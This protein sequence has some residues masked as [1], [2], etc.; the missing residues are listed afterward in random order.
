MNE[1]ELAFSVLRKWNS[2]IRQGRR[3]CG[4]REYVLLQS[5]HFDDVLQVRVRFAQFYDYCCY[6]ICNTD[7]G[8]H[9]CVCR[10]INDDMLYHMSWV[11]AYIA[12]ICGPTFIRDAEVCAKRLQSQTHTD[13]MMYVYTR[14]RQRLRLLQRMLRAWKARAANVKS[15]KTILHVIRHHPQREALTHAFHQQW[16]VTEQ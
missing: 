2:A 9:I 10:A 12:L 11:F 1:E 5:E 14:T 7:D 3:E 8:W 13:C 4:V 6:D 15:R 16:C